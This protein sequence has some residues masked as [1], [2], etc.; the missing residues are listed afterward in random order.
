[1]LN[2]E[3]SKQIISLGAGFDTTYFLLKNKFPDA[4]F[5]YIEVDFPD[6]CRA[7]AQKFHDCPELQGMIGCEID[8][9]TEIT[10]LQYKLLHGDL[11]EVSELERKLSSYTLKEA[12]T[13]IIA[14]CV[15]SYI[16]SE[17]IDELLQSLTGLFDN[18]GIIVYDIICPNDAFGRTMMQNLAARGIQ[19]KGVSK[20]PNVQSQVARYQRYF[21]RAQGFDMLQIY[22]TCVDTNEKHR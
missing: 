18:A 8:P 19:L 7:K 12:P 17:K 15:F 13:L 2:E 1:M 10:T 21:E 14:E 20:Y 4:Q 11:R 9:S 22:N 3:P 6:V 5:T 16:E